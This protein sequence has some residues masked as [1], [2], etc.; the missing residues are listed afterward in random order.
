MNWVW[1]GIGK[2]SEVVKLIPLTIF[3]V[4]WK[5]RNNRAFDECMGDLSKIRDRW[6]H[7]FGT[8][9]LGHDVYGWDDFGKLFDILTDM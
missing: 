8:L 5:E 4:V 2:K 9:I 1:D 7:T 3:Q 6:I